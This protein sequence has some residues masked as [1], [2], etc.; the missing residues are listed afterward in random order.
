MNARALASL[1]IAL[2]RR[3]S[4][5]PLKR[6]VQRCAQMAERGNRSSGG[7]VSCPSPH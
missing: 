2:I 7:R 6:D 1:G 5:R 3:F 4:L